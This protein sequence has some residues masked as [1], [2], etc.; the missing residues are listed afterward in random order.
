MALIE[1]LNEADRLLALALSALARELL[2]TA[3][4]ASDFRALSAFRPRLQSVT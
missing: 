2:V 3:G 1:T 4:K